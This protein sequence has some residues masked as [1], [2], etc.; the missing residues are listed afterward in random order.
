MR[1]IRAIVL[2]FILS[3]SFVL[4]GGGNLNREG[5]SFS[6]FGGL[7][8]LNDKYRKKIFDKPLLYSGFRFDYTLIKRVR[9]ACS[10]G[11]YYTQHSSKNLK[12]YS[13]QIGGKVKLFRYSSFAFYGRMTGE[14]VI[15]NEE[16]RGCF[17][18]GSTSFKETSALWKT[19]WQGEG[20]NL[21][22]ESR[23]NFLPEISFTFILGYKFLPADLTTLNLYDMIIERDQLDRLDY[24]PPTKLDINGMYANFGVNV[25]LLDKE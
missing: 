18:K 22:I 23:Y 24:T 5:I 13:G 10:F 3:A 7:Q 15:L 2:L 4:G 16:E 12:G 17:N 21:G 19:E 6:Y 25:H 14:F 11:Y 9:L 1:S 20:I 8:G